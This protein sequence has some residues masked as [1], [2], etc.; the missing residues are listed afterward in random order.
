MRAGQ[1]AFEVGEEFE[2]PVRTIDGNW[3]ILDLGILQKGRI[4]ISELRDERM[5]RVEDVV[6]V[7]DI[8]RCRVKEFKFP[9]VEL[10]MR[11][12]MNN[13]TLLSD[14]REGKVVDAKVAVI[15]RRMGAFLDVGA[16]TNALL[17]LQEFQR[18]TKNEKFD[19]LNTTLLVN[20]TL[21]VRIAQ[22]NVAKGHIT[23]ALA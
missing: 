17:P 21:K 20:S 8:V 23:V 11:D 4:H 3:T 5:D 6:K 19:N 16:V 22:V 14:L 1:K 7:G 2:G 10:T 15:N 9:F 18:W 13:R 12:Y